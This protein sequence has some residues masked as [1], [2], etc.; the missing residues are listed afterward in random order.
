M[1]DGYLLNMIIVS[2]KYMFVVVIKCLFNGDFL[3]GVIVV[4]LLNRLFFLG[5]FLGNNFVF[6][7]DKKLFYLNL[8]DKCVMF[9]FILGL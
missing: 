3:V 5:N 9:K 7:F 1:C 4:F 8:L 2:Y 6:G